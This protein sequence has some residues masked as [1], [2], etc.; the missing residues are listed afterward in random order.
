M[1]P[2]RTLLA[3]CIDYAGLFP[4]AGLDMLSA[5]R[6]YAQYRTGED[7]WALGR[8]VVPA[9]RLAELQAAAG[10]CIR[11][12]SSSRPWQ[13]SVLAGADP[14]SDIETVI[15]FNQQH[16]KSV[17]FIAD[18]LELKAT[19]TAAIED[20]MR[21]VPRAVRAYI[22]IPVNRDPYPVLTTI[23]RLGARAKARTGGVTADA[24][25][26]TADL[27]RFIRSCLQAG[28]PF[29]ATAGLHHPLR[30]EYRLTYAPDSPSGVMFGFLNL[31]LATAFVHAGMPD[32]DAALL[33]EEKSSHAFGLDR[34]GISWRDHRL[35]GEALRHARQ[36]GM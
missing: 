31:L 10:E 12:A 30:A 3:E 29:K 21:L 20:V 26:S 35:D 11:Q 16:S 5:V 34:D 22:E 18:T 1:I 9:N 6:N 2:I 17:S 36:E 7:A 13:L 14:G 27:L 8:F 15:R 33:L 23:A 19:S 4:P 28:I 24:F 25:P 32:S